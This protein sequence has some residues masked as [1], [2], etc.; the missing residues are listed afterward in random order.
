MSLEANSFYSFFDPFACDFAPVDPMDLQQ[1]LNG[2]DTV[3]KV[4]KVAHEN[5]TVHIIPPPP[6]FCDSP[7]L[8][9]FKLRHTEDIHTLANFWHAYSNTLTIVQLLKFIRALSYRQ[10]KDFA[11]TIAGE[12]LDRVLFNLHR[13]DVDELCLLCKYLVYFGLP[14]SAITDRAAQL[15]K[16][17]IARLNPYI[18]FLNIE[19][20]AW[21]ADSVQCFD[22]ENSTLFTQ[23]ATSIR[24]SSE[25]T[26]S[27]QC[28]L[29]L[30]H[31]FSKSRLP[32]SGLLQQL[33][34]ELLEVPFLP[35]DIKRLFLERLI[36]ALSAHRE[37]DDAFLCKLLKV[38]CKQIDHLGPMGIFAL[39]EG[40]SRLSQPP[41][42][43]VIEICEQIP[44]AKSIGS[45]CKIAI[46]AS[47]IRHTPQA[48]GYFAYVK[49]ALT[50]NNK[51]KLKQCGYLQLCQLLIAFKTNEPPES[52]FIQD[53]EELFINTGEGQLPFVKQ[54]EQNPHTLQALH[55]IQIAAAIKHVLQQKEPLTSENK[56]FLVTAFEAL[57]TRQEEV[58]EAIFMQY[59][60]ASSGTSEV[61]LRK[62]E[63][64]YTL[65]SPLSP[66]VARQLSSLF[67]NC[68][69]KNQ[70]LF[71]FFTRDLV[72]KITDLSENV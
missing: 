6:G 25:T 2:D 51:E 56:A 54:I 14:G 67:Q 49:K 28:K 35:K 36:Y 17:A 30:I 29:K 40:T 11:H 66:P 47:L 61:A 32:T 65:N 10:R 24:L 72:Q 43:L 31:A 20:L 19:Q 70:N 38:Q 58:E 26:A 33:Q 41:E 9:S 53:I 62:A 69:E 37:C 44:Q 63:I 57:F 71:T 46:L 48:E 18:P 8:F 64:F 52:P 1:P 50:D 55:S 13:F 12:I 39:I 68:L 59:A 16:E 22:L 4:K 7:E 42:D 45:L 15:Y 23:I 27:T 60:A 3:R 34:S 5:G 21:I